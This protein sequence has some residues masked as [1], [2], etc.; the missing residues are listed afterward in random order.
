M[1]SKKQACAIFESAGL[2]LYEKQFLQLSKYLE[3]LL[4]TNQHMNLTA[5]TQPEEIWRKHFLDSAVLLQ[6]ITIP[7]G[8]ACLDVGTGAGFPG[9]VLAV[10]RPDLYIVLL[11]SLKKRAR[12]LEE[13]AQTLG[14]W[15]VECVHARAEDAA[16]EKVYREMFDFVTARAVAV[17]PVLVEYCLPYVK[18]DGVFVAMK[19]PSEDIAF[20]ETAAEK[21]GGMVEKECVYSLEG[22]GTRKLYI[23]RKSVHTPAAYPRRGDKI[24]KKP[25]I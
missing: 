20:A 5:I 13:T 22:I 23:I 8:A 2:S 19:G 21:L 24:K 11:E 14:L 3:L 6:Q 15:N 12:F 9:M 18:V 7:L 17:L 10:L 1:I 25:L 4:E 16:K